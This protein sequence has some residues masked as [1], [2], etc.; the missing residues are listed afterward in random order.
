MTEGIVQ[1]DCREVLAE[2]PEAEFDAIFADPPY[3]LQLRQPLYRPNQTLVDAVNDDWDKVGDFHD[4]DA[5]TREWLSACRR[6]LKPD[7]TI[8]VIGTYHNIFR[9][10]SILQDLGYWILN[11]VVW[12]KTNPMPNFRGARLTNA[13]ETLIWAAKSREAKGRLLNYKSLKAGNE[14]K[15]MRSEWVIPICS[16]AERT[17]QNG[18]KAHSTQK[19]EALL[20][21]V[22]MA[23][24]SWGDWVLDPFVGSGTTAAVAKRL[25]R[26]CVGIEQDEGYVKVARKRLASVAR[27]DEALRELYEP[28]DEPRPLRVP[29]VNLVEQGVLAVGQELYFNGSPDLTARIGADGTL[30]APDGARGSIHKIA[31]LYGSVDRLNGWTVWFYLGDSGEMVSIDGLRPHSP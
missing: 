5:F 10:G 9:V 7:G 15:Q 1:G 16:G 23:C 13:H 19:P 14:D 20:H 4:Y 31:G 18:R 3:N 26:R 30:L 11:D 25:G 28:Y 2:F 24:T 8:W 29:F 22:L 12:I 27:P 17:L 6:V 21:R